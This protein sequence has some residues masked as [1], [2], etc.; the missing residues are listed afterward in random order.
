MEGESVTSQQSIEQLSTLDLKSV[1]ELKALKQIP[2][3]GMPVML[4]CLKLQ[5]GISPDVDI[6]SKADPKTPTWQAC[7]KMMKNPRK[8]VK[9][10]MELFDKLGKDATLDRHV[11][12]VRKT[13]KPEDLDLFTLKCISHAMWALGGWV[14]A[15]LNSPQK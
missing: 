4:A 14:Q 15:V 3:K 2:E 12:D 6:T 10:C 9:E 1:Q 8:F 5:A 11:E 7:Q 13:L